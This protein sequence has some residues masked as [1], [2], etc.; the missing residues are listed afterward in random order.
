MKEFIKTKQFYN[1]LRSYCKERNYNLFAYKEYLK[2]HDLNYCK[3]DEN[4]LEHNSDLSLEEYERYLHIIRCTVEFLYDTMFDVLKIEYD[5]NTFDTPK[6][7]SK[8]F[9][10][11][12]NL[13]N[14]LF[15]GRW[16]VKPTLTKFS[17][18]DYDDCECDD[19]EHNNEN[20]IIKI[21]VNLYSLCSHHL[22]PFG[23]FNNSDANAIICYIP[24]QV[25]PGLSKI[26]RYVNY[27]SRRGWMQEKL[28]ET[29]ANSL[30]EEFK[31]KGVYVYLE[32]IIHTCSIHRG[33]SDD[34]LMSTEYYNGIF[35][36]N[37][38]LLQNAR[39]LIK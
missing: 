16:G 26:G 23:T 35:N 10:P 21:K 6:R 3:I 12:Y 36:E 7:L 8:M 18:G 15:S 20:N 22:L 32:N 29:I 34:T 9:V 28:S 38:Q 11:N 25:Y 30:L 5:A 37:E 39:S 14:E 4:V 17:F 31:L 27:I 19:V 24:N 2:A 1:M 13:T 33:Y